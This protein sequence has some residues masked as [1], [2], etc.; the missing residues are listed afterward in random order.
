LSPYI[1][2]L[3]VFILASTLLVFF[4]LIEV[5]VTIIPDNRQKKKRA[6]RIDGFCRVVFPAVFLLA[7]IVIFM[8]PHG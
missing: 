1:T 4:S 2:R 3:D 7:S 5:V 6:K 8:P